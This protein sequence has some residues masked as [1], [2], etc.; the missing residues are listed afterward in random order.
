MSE[1]SNAINSNR[2]FQKFSNA[3]NSRKSAENN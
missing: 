1:T 3:G 2:Q